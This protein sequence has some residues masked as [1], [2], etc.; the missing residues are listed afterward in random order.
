M[1]HRTA[2][3]WEEQKWFMAPNDGSPQ[4]ITVKE[5]EV[6]TFSGLY[7]VNG[8]ALHRQKE[9]MGFVK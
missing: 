1:Y 5:Q 7:D 2:R 8:V 6:D 3:P 4:S 9:K